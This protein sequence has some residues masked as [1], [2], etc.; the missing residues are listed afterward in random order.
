M[1]DI[2][3]H[4]KEYLSHKCE[5]CGCVFGFSRKDV[6]TSKF[7][8]AP[9][10]THHEDWKMKKYEGKSWVTCPEC[11]EQYYLVEG[12]LDDVKPC[13]EIKENISEKDWWRWMAI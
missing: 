1:V 5:K 6:M 4:G 9:L 10:Y 3:E 11:G 8:V 13:Q 2:K 12:S 7:E